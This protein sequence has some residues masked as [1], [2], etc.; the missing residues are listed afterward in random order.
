MCPE[1]GGG[2]RCGREKTVSDVSDLS[3]LSK[4]P[5]AQTVEVVSAHARVKAIAGRT[6]T[7]EGSGAG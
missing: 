2:R 5:S 6:D 7:P 4:S 1:I 3:D